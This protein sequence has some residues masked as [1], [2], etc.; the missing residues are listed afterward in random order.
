MFAFE[1]AEVE[2]RMQSPL[3]RAADTPVEDD[4][5]EESFP[6]EDETS[7]LAWRYQ[8]MLAADRLRIEARLW[9]KRPTGNPNAL[10]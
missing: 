6:D 8:Q 10:S 3:R 7:D 2:N 9:A 5:S 4:Y 1:L